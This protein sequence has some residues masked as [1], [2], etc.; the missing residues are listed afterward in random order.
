LTV[1]RSGNRRLAATP[2]PVIPVANRCAEAPRLEI[3][4]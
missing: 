3:D 4:V 1:I 2:D